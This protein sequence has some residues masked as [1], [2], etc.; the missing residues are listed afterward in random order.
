M[1]ISQAMGRFT[2]VPLTHRQALNATLVYT[3]RAPQKAKQSPAT[4]MRAL[5]VELRMTQ[6]AL[7]RRAGVTQAQ[8]DRMEKG[9]SDA[10]LGTWRK[11]FAAMFCE[12]LVVP[13]ALKRPGDAVAEQR[14]A[15]PDW[16]RPWS[17]PD[18]LGR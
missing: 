18:S 4:Y 15:R 17:P 9:R 8:I 1:L 14:L 11:I 5:R 13:H 3:T 7:A 2:Q 10:R 12:L 16:V 6:S